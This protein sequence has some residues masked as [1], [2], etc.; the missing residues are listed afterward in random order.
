MIACVVIEPITKS[1]PYFASWTL[2]RGLVT[3]GQAITPGCI[4]FH[5][6][7]T[8]RLIPHRVQFASW[9]LFQGLVARAKKHSW[10]HTFP[11][12]ADISLHPSSPTT[13]KL[14]LVS[15]SGREKPINGFLPHSIPRHADISLHILHG[16]GFCK[17]DFFRVLIVQR[18]AMTPCRIHFN[19]TPTYRLQFIPQHLHFLS[20][21][22]SGHEGPSDDSMLHS[23]PRD[24]DISLNE[25]VVTRPRR[26]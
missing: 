21:T 6:Q 25:R 10:P 1:L 23:F 11:Q 26:N 19:N 8:F 17:L 16:Y 7:P 18:Q 12:Q 14:D 5:D 3:T 13:C 15:R 2:S 9:T 22:L 20:W 24:V 4:H